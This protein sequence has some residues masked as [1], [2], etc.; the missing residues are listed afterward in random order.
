MAT[1]N[2]API[3][4][5]RPV[6]YQ[7]H[8]LSSALNMF[9]GTTTMKWS[10]LFAIMGMVDAALGMTIFF[11]FGRKIIFQFFIFNAVSFTAALLMIVVFTL[12]LWFAGHPQRLDNTIGRMLFNKRVRKFIDKFSIFDDRVTEAEVQRITGFVGYDPESGLYRTLVNK[13][14]DGFWAIRG[15]PYKGN[16]CY[17]VTAK[18]D[19]T[20]TDHQVIIENMYAS[21]KTFK[22]GHYKNTVMITGNTATKVLQEMKDKLKKPNIDKFSEQA[23]YSI[24]EM[25]RGQESTKEPIYLILFGLP[26]TLR[27]ETA[28]QNM[29]DMRA[30]YEASINVKGIKTELITDPYILSLLIKG[31]LTC[32]MFVRGDLLGKGGKFGN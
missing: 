21:D 15:H 27:K 14:K 1:K 7:P 4:K 30:G 17:V 10:T 18:P 3:E 8:V 11:T 2:L 32:K 9:G 24:L 5:M 22:A 31:A 19:Y 25:Y 29:R 13:A 28:L 23:L 12:W 20:M 6:R 16:W 26:F